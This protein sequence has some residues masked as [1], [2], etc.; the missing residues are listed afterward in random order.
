MRVTIR[1]D[2]AGGHSTTAE[3]VGFPL[4]TEDGAGRYLV[5]V[6][7]LNEAPKHW[8][9]RA[10]PLSGLTVLERSYIDIGAGVPGEGTP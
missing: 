8:D 4:Q 3:A 5:F 1:G 7:D 10:E 9:R 6:D 2:F